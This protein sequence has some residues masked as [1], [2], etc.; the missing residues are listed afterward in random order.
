MTLKLPRLLDK[1]GVTF[2][3]DV[4]E[5]FQGQEAELVRDDQR[6]RLEVI[7]VVWAV[8]PLQIRVLDR[9]ELRWDEWFFA[10]RDRLFDTSGA[11][12]VLRRDW[13]KALANA[14]GEL[15]GRQDDDVNSDDD[16]DSTEASATADA[17]SP[18][19]EPAVGI[20]LGTTYSVVAHLDQQGRPTS[21]LNANGDVLTPSVVLFDREGAIVGKEAVLAATL[22]PDCVA[23]CVKR[24]MGAKH[25]RKPIKGEYLPP[26]VISSYILRRLRA[27][28]E[29]KLGP[30][31]KA[32]ITVPAYFDET[33]R[34][35]TMDAGR[36]AGLEVLD[37]LNEP[38]AAAI[39]FGYQEGFLDQEGRV[40]GDEPL[41]VLVYDLGGGTFDVTVVEMA[42]Q[43]FK[44]IATD[45][46]VQLGGKDWDEKLVEIAVR[47]IQDAAAGDPRDDPETSIDLWIAAELAKKTLS[48]RTKAT[49]IVRHQEKRHKL[50]ITREEFEEA[51]APLVL[52]TR[53]T[54]EIVVMQ[55]GL[56]W[57]E[58]DKVLVVGGSTRMP[59]I[60]RMLS[61]LAGKH[62]D[63]SVSP[64]EAVAHGAALYADLLL[65]RQGAGGG[66]TRFSVTN[67]NSHSLGVVGFDPMSGRMVNRIIIGKNTPLPH[68]A[69]R[70]FKTSTE[71]QPNVKISVVEGESELPEA[72]TEVGTCVIRDLPPNLPA[73]WPVE[74]RYAY[75]ENG[76]L[77]VAAKLLGHAAH[78][79]A[80]FTRDNSLDDDD[81]LLWAECLADEAAR[82]DW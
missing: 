56:T 9:R 82:N 10:M 68:A 47:R 7:D 57:D 75:Q 54:A 27:D 46:D 33:R 76:R 64:D 3:A 34:R 6:Y 1:Y 72:C 4:L 30:V 36:M 13:K 15:L 24:D 20:D 39:L 61:E 51:T 12:I 31:S 29:R 50:E 43:S 5:P 42:T 45:G 53:M 17:R 49:M 28:A 37:I 81:L 58:I 62:V 25:Y 63:Q 2:I 66:H 21:I 60:K 44:A 77:Q 70:R 59:M 40:Q 71:N 14:A 52:R 74:V 26:E 55:A 22:E 48:E 35:A 69:A 32:V 65:Q 38:T 11:T 18:A 23:D 80:E 79:I 16:V 78:V 8:A 19:D 67:V 41:R 73:G